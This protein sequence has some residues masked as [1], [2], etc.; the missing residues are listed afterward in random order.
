VR[1]LLGAKAESL[2]DIKLPCYASYKVDGW[3]ARWQGLEFFSR[4]NK[5]IPNRALQSY[6]VQSVIPVGYDGE[7]IVGEPNDPFVFRKTDAFCKTMRAPLPPEGIRFFVFD[8]VLLDDMSFERRMHTL[9]SFPPFVIRLE[10]QF[11]NSYDVLESFENEAVVSG[12]EGIVTRHPDGR[13][14]NGRSTMREQ[15]LVKVK[16]YLEEEVRIIRA[17][18]KLHNANPAFI[19][20][21]GYTKRSS[22]A[23][24]KV[25]AGTLGALVVDWRG[26]ELRVGTGW[27]SRTAGELWAIR[28]SLPDKKCTIRFSPPTKD[29]PRQ[30]VW[31]CL[32][33]DL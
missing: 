9:E 21:T 24:G 10:Q 5:T 20:E 13:Y 2:H 33:S 29:L 22:H 19:S 28:D 15:Y 12:F 3:R 8:N 6:A 23:E 26:Q 17:E 14:K 27:D 7:L 32:R 1:L 11:I 18:E 25:P 16:R 31:K 30:P 4:N